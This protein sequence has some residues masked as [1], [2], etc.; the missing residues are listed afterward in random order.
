V[1]LLLITIILNSLL[2]VKFYSL[3]SFFSGFFFSFIIVGLLYIAIFQS[4]RSAPS[5]NLEINMATEKDDFPKIKVF[6]T[7]TAC[8]ILASVII[9]FRYLTFFNPKGFDTPYYVYVLKTFYSRTFTPDLIF[10][11]LVVFALTP[12]AYVFN[13]DTFLIGIAIPFYIGLILTIIIF[14]SFRIINRSL[15][16]SSLATTFAVSNFFFIRLT[17]DL[18]SQTL[19]T[20]LFYL[21]IAM[22]TKLFRMTGS[23]E[24]SP[25]DKNRF[26]LNISIVLILMLLT[27]VTLSIV[28]YIFLGIIFLIRKPKVLRPRTDNSTEKLII[29]VISLAVIVIILIIII[30]GYAQ[31]LW[32]LYWKIITYELSPFKPRQ[33]WEWIIYKE[34]L[35]ILA[36]C[37]LSVVFFI[38]K[39]GAFAESDLV[40]LLA[41]WSSYIFLLIF[42]TGYAQSYRLILSIPISTIAGNGVYNIIKEPIFQRN[43]PKF[44]KIRVS[45][46]V[47]IGLVVTVIATLLPSATIPEYEY[48]PKNTA[49]LSYLASHYGF[50]SPDVT[51][52]INRQATESPYWYN[53][54]LGRNVFIGNITELLT[55]NVT[56][57]IIF[58]EDLY[59]LVGL[60]RLISDPLGNGV[61]LVNTTYLEL[62]RMELFQ[63][64]ATQVKVNYTDYPMNISNFKI[65]GRINVANDDGIITTFNDT[66][67]RALIGGITR[68]LERQVTVQELFLIYEGNTTVNIAV[69]F[70]YSNTFLGYARIQGIA[71]SDFCLITLTNSIVIDEYRITLSGSGTNT[72]QTLKLKLISFGVTS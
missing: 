18:F 59:P 55:S 60:A 47:G 49:I 17:Y 8:L 1:F 22:L 31:K 16:Y 2:S 25:Q 63:R 42:V 32:N 21:M 71:N 41:L 72:T 12:L 29:A 70:Y 6:L 20:A 50:D 62:P 30:S 65:F 57:K 46:I 51:Y 58:H 48:F 9:G 52:L 68:K 19:F 40:N 43:F 54:Y 66:D 34:T 24:L 23:T 14:T 36:L 11:P 28:T 69:E 67:P 4:F 13:G 53:A 3:T 35:P 61:Y 45:Q 33:G 64:W 56:T 39:N 37:S 5:Q 44:K 7:L 27:D 10:H 15:A 38:V 26:L